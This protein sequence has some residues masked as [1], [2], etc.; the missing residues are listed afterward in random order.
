MLHYRQLTPADIPQARD[1]VTRVYT[2]SFGPEVVERWHGDIRAM[3]EH[4]LD[5]PGQAA[6]VAL[7]DGAVIGFAAIRHRSPQAGPLEGRYDPATTCELGRVTV[8]PAW[9][10]RGI[11]LQLVELARLWAGGRYSVIS[12]HTDADNEP[13]LRLWRR[14]CTP[15]LEHQG[16]VYFELPIATPVPSPPKE[17]GHVA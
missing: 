9:R 7:A 4:Y 14:L 16:T 1:L 5:H 12:L 2:Q 11:A 17:P 6:F 8:D 10:G 3:Q 15:V 13:A